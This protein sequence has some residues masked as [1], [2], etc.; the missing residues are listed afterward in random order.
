MNKLSSNKQIGLI[1]VIGLIIRIVALPFVHTTNA[2]AVSRIII[3]YKWLQNPYFTISDVW[4]PLHHYLNAFIIWVSGGDLI[5]SLKI[6]QILFAVATAIPLYKFTLNE[7]KTTEG[8]FFVSLT[9]LFIP[10]VVRNSFQVLSGIPSAFFIAASMYFL[11]QGKKLDKP[12]KYGVLAGLSMTIAGGIRYEAWLL[13]AVFTLV[14]LLQKQWKMVLFFWVF[15]MIFPF[16]WMTGGYIVHGDLFYG[17]HGAYRW[18]ITMMGG[19]DNFNWR[20]LCWR[21][22]YFPITYGILMTPLIT[23]ATLYYTIKSVKKREPEMSIIWWLLPFVVLMIAFIYKAVNGTLLLQPRFV[24]LLL[25]TSI[26]F[27]ALVFMNKDHLKAKKIIAWV[28]IILI[29]PY[30][31]LG[32]RNIQAFPRIKDKTTLDLLKIIHNEVDKNG[33]QSLILDFIGWDNTYFIWLRSGVAPDNIFIVNGAKYGKVNASELAKKIEKNKTGIIVKKN[34]SKMD[35]Y[36]HFLNDTVLE[37]RKVANYLYLKP[38]IINSRITLYKYKS[39][40]KAP[41]IFYSDRKLLKVNENAIH[42]IE[43]RI[44]ANT[45]Q[46]NSMIHEAEIRGIEIDTL[47]RISAINLYKQKLKKTH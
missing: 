45:Q 35:E 37:V 5:Y 27:Y 4:L 9:Y 10:I 26:P 40:D 46:Y 16:F 17:S 7:F 42:Q 47:I 20:M 6:L 12:I 2:D 38:I 29:L 18:N 33:T 21:L 28:I 36:F 43:E 34:E 1:I 15:A 24:I 13:I 25:I 41:L 30:S 11:S 8:A 32:A 19:N 44:K 39:G 23:I 14:L 22:V 3:A 31:Y